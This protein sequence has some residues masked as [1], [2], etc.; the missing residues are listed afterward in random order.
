MVLL[1]FNTKVLQTWT[2][3]RIA[4]VG[5]SIHKFTP[6]AGQGGN[7]SIESAAA[8]ANALKRLADTVKGRPTKAQVEDSLKEY[9]KSRETRIRAIIEGCNNLTR[10][11]TMSNRFNT[12]FVNHLIYR[13]GDTLMVCF[14]L[15]TLT[16]RFITD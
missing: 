6:D 1:S 4:C 16:A 13:L 7:S 2:F 5:D 3:G 11:H 9:Q 15:A 10:V 12:F 8:L 14:W